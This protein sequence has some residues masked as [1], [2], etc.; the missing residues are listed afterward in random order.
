MK[1]EVTV[2]Q[3]VADDAP[4]IIEFNLAM[5]KETEDRGLSPDILAAGVA[6]VFQDARRATYHV[7]EIDGRVVGSLM[8][9]TEWSDW[10]NGTFL[11]I[12]SVYV[13]PGFRRRGVYRALHEAVRTL[14]GEMEGI[15]GIRL[16]VERENVSAQEVYRTIGMRETTYRLFE[17]DFGS[18]LA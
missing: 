5:A 6:A 12:Q 11:W 8:L 14:A 10:R 18:S 16:Y 17:E 2:R 9:T 7:A 4:A 3:A 13:R 1:S 15:C